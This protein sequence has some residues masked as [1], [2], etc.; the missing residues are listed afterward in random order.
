MGWG[1][2]GV[3]LDKGWGQKKGVPLGKGWGQS[4]EGPQG[5]GQSQEEDRRRVWPH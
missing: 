5:R 4:W 1:Q 2:R 3:P